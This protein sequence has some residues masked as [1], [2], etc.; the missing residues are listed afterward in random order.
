MP[1]FAGSTEFGGNIGDFAMSPADQTTVIL[2]IA[3]FSAFGVTLAYT[4]FREYL[5]GRRRH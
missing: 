1:G 4:S 3:M 2:A 5:A